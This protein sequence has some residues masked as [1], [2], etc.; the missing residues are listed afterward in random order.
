MQL[1]RKI[2]PKKGIY[3]KGKIEGKQYPD[4]DI[5]ER[6]YA[7]FYPLDNN[8][9][10]FITNIR[11]NK[12]SSPYDINDINNYKIIE[13]GEN[14]FSVYCNEGN[15]KIR[16]EHFIPQTLNFKE[17]IHYRK[18]IKSLC[19]GEITF[20]YD[21]DFKQ[22]DSNKTLVNENNYKTYFLDAVKDIF[23]E[24]EFEDS[25]YENALSKV[26][27]FY[28]NKIKEIRMNLFGKEKLA[29]LEKEF[30]DKCKLLCKTLLEMPWENQ[31]WAFALNDR[32]FKGNIVGNFV[33][34]KDV[35]TNI[36]KLLKNKY[37]QFDKKS[38]ENKFVDDKWGRFEK[39]VF[40]FYPS[41]T[42]CF[43]EVTPNT[44]LG[45][46]SEN[47]EIECFSFKNLVSNWETVKFDFLSKKD[48]VNTLIN[49]GI[50]TKT[51]FSVE[52]NYLSYNDT[53]KIYENGPA[54]NK[55]V[56]ET[57]N[58]FH[59]KYEKKFLKKIKSGTGFTM[60]EKA[61]QKNLIFLEDITNEIIKD[62]KKIFNFDN[63][64]K[65]LFHYHLLSFLEEMNKKQQNTIK[66]FIRNV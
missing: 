9:K 64:C 52:N 31:E 34:L 15:I 54:F 65:K 14:K 1:I 61:Y 20:F 33:S 17:Y 57:L 55:I 53:E 27:T 51:N 24:I 62:L 32:W 28:S 48:I 12:N 46:S 2:A 26:D 50:L 42:D 49:K 22:S 21:E 45:K 18:K 36:Q 6:G 8:L 41:N 56:I 16:T 37:S 5:P 63:A 44:V 38:L 47:T 4:L 60:K 58:P 19:N 10:D 23:N 30:E 7:Y 39:E 59:K 25:S 13:N 40:L 29:V 11:S 43:L 66:D 35:Y 3:D